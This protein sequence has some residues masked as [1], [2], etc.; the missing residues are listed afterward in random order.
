MYSVGEKIVYGENGVC[1]VIK[2]APLEISGASKDKLYYYLAPLIGTGVYYSPVDSGAFMRPVISREEAEALAASGHDLT[3]QLCISKK[4]HLILPTHR[5]LDAAY[6][7]AKGSAKIGTTGKGI[8]PTYTDKVS[9]NGMRVGDV[10]SAD[11]RQIYARAKAR[12]E[13]ILRG[14]GY[15]YDIAELERKWFEAVE[16]LKRFNII[17]SEYFVFQRQSLLWLHVFGYDY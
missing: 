9:R 11:F 5:I 6:E 17:D 10:L 3:K 1:T 16:Y 15:E 12:H 7:A 2:I 13:S 4:A 14:L 8:G